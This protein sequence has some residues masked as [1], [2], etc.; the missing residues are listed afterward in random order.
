[1]N[2]DGQLALINAEKQ[3]CRCLCLLML[4]N[5]TLMSSVA[6]HR[7]CVCEHHQMHAFI[8]HYHISQTTENAN[9]YLTP[10]STN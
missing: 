2:K 7:M 3:F 4:T 1:M 10:S 5:A 9:S 6:I 8:K